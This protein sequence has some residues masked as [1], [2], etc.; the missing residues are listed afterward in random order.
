MMVDVS[1]GQLVSAISERASGHFRIFFVV[2]PDAEPTAIDFFKPRVMRERGNCTR[3]VDVFQV[4]Y[5]L[6]LQAPSCRQLE[7]VTRLSG[8]GCLS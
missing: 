4:S 6:Y 8:L 7:Q 3:L 2:Q 1:V 5:L